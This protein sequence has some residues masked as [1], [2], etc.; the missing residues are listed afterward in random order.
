M[1]PEHVLKMKFSEYLY[2]EITLTD[3]TDRRFD[4][5]IDKARSE[6]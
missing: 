1:L 2:R 5:A 4:D 3:V 6:S